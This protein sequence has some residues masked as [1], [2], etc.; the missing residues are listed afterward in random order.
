MACE[1]VRSEGEEEEE[2]KEEEEESYLSSC[3]TLATSC[4][5]CVAMPLSLGLLWLCHFCEQY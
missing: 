4:S 1:T 5:R 2:E 3:A